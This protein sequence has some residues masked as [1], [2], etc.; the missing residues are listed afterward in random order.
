MVHMMAA[1]ARGRQPAAGY[2]D[3]D[4]VLVESRA[5][6][7]RFGVLFDAY[8]P[9]IRRYAEARV[10]GDLAEDVASETFL[11]A[12]RGRHRFDA[13]ERGGQVRAWLYGIA[14]NLIRRQR[15]DELRRYRALARSGAADGGEPAHDERVA[16]QV[17]AQAIQR[18]LAAALADL[19]AR[20]RD[21]F[22]LVALGGLD[23]GEVAA[24]LD[25]PQGTVASRLNRA[26]RKVRAALGG[27]D[28]TRLDMKG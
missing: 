23:Y 7:E 14:T 10:S 22:L 20:E 8:Y 24:A 26:R 13:S 19:S 4:A 28:P 25:I 2:R 1:P 11:I 21:T 18:E 16:A 6:P 15:R 17:T 12:F 5:A 27:T 3:D 9:Q